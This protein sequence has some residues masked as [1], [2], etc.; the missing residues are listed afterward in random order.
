MKG[1]LQDE[2]INATN[3]PVNS[4]EESRFHVPQAKH[5]Q[6][7]EKSRSQL[8]SHIRELLKIVESRD[9]LPAKKTPRN[10]VLEAQTK[11]WP[12]KR[13]NDR[14]KK[15]VKRNKRF[16]ISTKLEK[17]YVPE[18]TKPIFVRR[19]CRKPLPTPPPPTAE[20]PDLETAKR[21]CENCQTFD[22]SR[23]ED[24]PPLIREMKAAWNKIQLRNYYRFIIRRNERESKGLTQ[25]G[26]KCSHNHCSHI[27]CS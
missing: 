5:K 9:D 4:T 26:N 14:I 15:P 2:P 13:S 18:S 24:D 19:Y 6:N 22:L 12:T 8:E 21:P 23:A 27:I 20:W 17:I 11:S 7:Y 16:E 1:S 3:E 10:F 25:C